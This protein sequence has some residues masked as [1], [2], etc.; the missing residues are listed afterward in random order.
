[1]AQVRLHSLWWLIA[2]S[3]KLI[4]IARQPS[5]HHHENF[6]LLLVIVC[7]DLLVSQFLWLR[8]I[9]NA[10]RCQL[11][12]VSPNHTQELHR[13]NAHSIKSYFQMKELAAFPHFLTCSDASSIRT[14]S[15]FNMPILYLI[16]SVFG[17][18]IVSMDGIMSS[19]DNCTSGNG[20]KTFTI[21]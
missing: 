21:R 18:N 5:Q 8:H 10:H 2:A 20:I 9:A 17:N 14:V 15:F 3:T 7:L 6:I 12:N 19:T 4:H 11:L 1:M 13:V 16:L